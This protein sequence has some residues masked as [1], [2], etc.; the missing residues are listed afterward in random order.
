LRSGIQESNGGVARHHRADLQ[1]NTPI[2]TEITGYAAS[3]LVFLYKHSGDP[4]YLERAAAAAR[5][6][7]GTAWDR[8]AHAMPFEIEPAEFAYF[9]DCGII[10]R[11]LLSV[12]RVT[13]EDELLDTAAAIG[14]HMKRDFVGLDDVH[15]IL[16]LPGKGPVARDALRWSRSPGCYQLKS[17]MAW[18]ELAD[19]TGDASYRAPYDRVLEG[20]LR[21]YAAFLPG[22]PERPKVMDRLHAYCYFLEGLLPHAAEQ[23]SCAAIADGI[24]RVGR[25]LRE[26]A[27]EFERSDVYAQ[28]LRMRI[29]ADRVGVTPLDREAAA[30]EASRLADFER[31]DGGF[32]FGRTEGRSWMPYVNPVSTA[33]ALQALAMWQGT[34]AAI[35]DLI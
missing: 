1:R 14:R 9:F 34:A 6:L 4:Q 21:S 8:A 2:S 5:F 32:W 35:P 31:P 3:A 12:W 10:V 15:P 16:A 26:I 7:A 33:F 24:G 17:A 20:S 22:H 11:G 13:R 29:Y 25:L 28:L 30:F 18:L 19:A 27:P 23:R